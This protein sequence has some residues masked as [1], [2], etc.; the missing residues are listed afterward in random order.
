M[1]PVGTATGYPSRSKKTI[2]LPKTDFPMNSNLPQNELDVRP[3]G[4]NGDFT[5]AF[6]IGAEGSH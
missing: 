3:L 1:F 2:D 5:S 4:A 6:G